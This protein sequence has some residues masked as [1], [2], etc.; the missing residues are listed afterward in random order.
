MKH[1][2]PSRG[3]CEKLE[4]KRSCAWTADDQEGVMSALVRIES[5]I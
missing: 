4:S 3:P 1:E 5:S 2:H